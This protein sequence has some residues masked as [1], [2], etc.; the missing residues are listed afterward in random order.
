MQFDQLDT[1]LIPSECQ[2]RVDRAASITAKVGPPRCVETVAFTV[3]GDR[4][5]LFMNI[6]H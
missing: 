3:E 5:Y 1:Y 4:N 2:W 6:V